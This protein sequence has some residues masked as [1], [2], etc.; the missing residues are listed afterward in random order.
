MKIYNFRQKPNTGKVFRKNYESQNIRATYSKNRSRNNFSG[1]D[2]FS[3]KN[4][5]IFQIIGL[6]LL[7]IGLLLSFQTIIDITTTT[8]QANASETE[9][10]LINDYN[11]QSNNSATQE[12]FEGIVTVKEVENVETT[13]TIESVESE[14][15]EQE[16]GFYTVKKGDTL[17]S[18]A[19]KFDT[20]VVKLVEIN[21]LKEPFEIK[22]GQK[23]KLD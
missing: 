3:T 7:T 17:F 1:F 18:I 22:A 8:T 19:N 15:P 2:I 13:E 14:E 16:D 10:R 4:T 21:N 23:L 9:V 20:K 12:K 5:F 11:H 6:G